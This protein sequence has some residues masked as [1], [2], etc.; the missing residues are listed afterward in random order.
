[1]NITGVNKIYVQTDCK[2]VRNQAWK[3]TE[4]L[5]S[6]LNGLQAARMAWKLYKLVEQTAR[7]P[8]GMKAGQTIYTSIQ[9]R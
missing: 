3:L 2:F 9:A 1:M 6:W 4:Q 5:G 7:G 8:N